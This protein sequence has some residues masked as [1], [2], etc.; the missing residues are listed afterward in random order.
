MYTLIFAG[1]VGENA[2]SLR[3]RICARLTQIDIRL[4]PEANQAVMAKE[5]ESSTSDSRVR[6]FVIPANEQAAIAKDTHEFARLERC[7]PACARV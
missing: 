1:G 4:D 3:E 5:A 7:D 6:V 2:V